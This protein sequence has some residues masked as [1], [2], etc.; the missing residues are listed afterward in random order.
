MDV[1]LCEVLRHRPLGMQWRE[2]FAIRILVNKTSYTGFL[3]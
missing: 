2:V 1:P 3:I